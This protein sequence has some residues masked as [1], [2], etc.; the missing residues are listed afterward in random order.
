MFEQDNIFEKVSSAICR[1]E[2]SSAN[3]RILDA[4]S[5]LVAL[6]N[7]NEEERREILFSI[8]CD[9]AAFII[10]L[11]AARCQEDVDAHVRLAP[12]I[13]QWA[14]EKGLL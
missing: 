1:N 7:F 8:S 3:G 14:R 5:L 10:S 9:D 11:F 4:Q 12:E 2:T 13:D 6:A